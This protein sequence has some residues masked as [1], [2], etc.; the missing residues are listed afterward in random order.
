MLFF[1]PVAE[2]WLDLAIFCISM[3][4]AR[5]LFCSIKSKQK[6]GQTVLKTATE[7]NPSEETKKQTY[8]K[9]HNNKDILYEA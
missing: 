5:A 1:G 2:F 7:D 4:S 9:P 3:S 6:Q 8:K